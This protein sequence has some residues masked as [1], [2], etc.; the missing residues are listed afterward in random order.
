MNNIITFRSAMVM[1]L[2]VMIVSNPASAI[3]HGTENHEQGESKHEHPEEMKQTQQE[4]SKITKAEAINLLDE[5]IAAMALTMSDEK[6]EEM[7]SNGPIMKEWHTHTVAIEDAISA[8][9]KE[10]SMKD[11]GIKKRIDG[12]LNQL[13]KTLDDFHT[14]THNRDT[15]KAETEIKKA[16]GAL[17]LLKVYLK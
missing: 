1:L 10:S 15:S 13:S 9:R 11:E 14:A 2:A 16:N 8:L 4:E 17:K 12:A 3:A 7:F 5:G 6:R